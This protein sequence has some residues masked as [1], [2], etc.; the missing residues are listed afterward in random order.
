MVISQREKPL[1]QCYCRNIFRNWKRGFRTVLRHIIEILEDWPASQWEKWQRS[2]KSFPAKGVTSVGWPTS[3]ATPT[4]RLQS[5]KSQN[6]GNVESFL[7]AQARF[8]PD[9]TLAGRQ[10]RALQYAA[11][12]STMKHNAKDLVWAFAANILQGNPDFISWDTHELCS[13]RSLIWVKKERKVTPV[14]I[15]KQCLGLCHQLRT[16]ELK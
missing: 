5:L 16:G 3:D 7:H 15:T 11:W 10:K 6:S 8:L 1:L 2:M 14:A 13:E 4:E 12:Q 9:H